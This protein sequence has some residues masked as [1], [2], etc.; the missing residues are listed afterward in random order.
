MEAGGGT[1]EVGAGWKGLDW[2]ATPH[3]S[4]SAPTRWDS[5]TRLLSDTVV[6]SACHWES[7]PA[8]WA[9]MGRASTS[10]M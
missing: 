10:W 9:A 1:G 2:S 7:F 6:M 5:E 8:A 3:W 4:V